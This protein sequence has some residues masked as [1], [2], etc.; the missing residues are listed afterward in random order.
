MGCDWSLMGEGFVFG[1]YDRIVWL[2]NRE[3]GKLRDV[4]YIKWM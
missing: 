1:F 3:E 4:Y 2:W